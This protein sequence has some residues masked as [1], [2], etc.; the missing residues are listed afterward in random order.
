MDCGKFKEY[1]DNFENL[2]D[3]QKLEMNKHAA[4]C[5]ACADE[6]DFMMSII[7][8][9]KSLPKITVPPDFASKL[10]AR[11]D[12]EERK[13]MTLLRRAALNIKQNRNRYAAVA[14][15]FALVAVLTANGT[16]LIDKMNGSDD[17]GVIIDETVVTNAD[18][19]VP[20]PSVFNV[21]EIDVKENN[22]LNIAPAPSGQSVKTAEKSAG[23]NGKSK[24]VSTSVPKTADSVIASAK[25][26]EVVSV[27]TA[28][29]AVS[30]SEPVSG[31]EEPAGLNNE[32]VQSMRGVYTLPTDNPASEPVAQSENVP[33]NYSLA[34]SGD[35]A[36]GRYYRL[37]KDGNPIEDETPKAVGSIIISS[38]DADKA[39]DV[40]LQ[41]S[42]ADGDF[43]MTDSDHLYLMLIELTQMGVDYSNYTPG[44]QGDI[45]FKLVIS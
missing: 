36:H 11:I 25:P 7:E 23:T 38:D 16:N 9:T 21:P 31:N 43:Y 44:Y 22:Q 10:N 26:Q 34:R 13:N 37:D 15:C 3:E 24:A 8:T 6:L 1:L 27:S 5:E 45:T 40:I 14:A 17:G 12:A 41:Y 2:T 33:G 39:M 35:I 42:Y 18:N 20:V 29:P 28:E 19:S 32:D 30:V 4:D